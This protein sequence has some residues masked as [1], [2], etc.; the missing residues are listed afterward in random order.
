M[1]AVRI[2]LSSARRRAGNFVL[3]AASTAAAV[4]MLGTFAAAA[5]SSSFAGLAGY[6]VYAK[7]AFV[8]STGAMLLFVALSGWF[9]SEHYLAK[10]RHE[11]AL[12]LLAGMR[13]RLAFGLL[14]AELAVAIGAGFAGGITIGA[15]LSRLFSLVLGALMRTDEP[16]S[17]AFGRVAIAAASGACLLQ[18]ALA[19][20]RAVVEVSR[21]S[22]AALIRSEREPEAPSKGSAPAAAAGALLIAASYA[23]AVFSRGVMAEN[24]IL[25]VLIGAVLGTF[26]VFD[27]LVPALA[28]FIR[29]RA[30]GLGAAGTFAAAQIA[31]R[32]RRNARL[33]ALT[34]V[35]I[36]MAAAA[37][38]TVLAIRDWIRTEGGTYGQD[39]L[40]GAL[41]FIGG[42][43]SF[44]FALSAVV[45]LASRAAADARDDLGR[46]LELRDLGASRGTVL[47]AL[48]LQNAFLF[49]LPLAFGLAHSAV[50]L[51]MLRSFATVSSAG[52]TLAVCAA[53]IACFALLVS[54][55]SR[56]QLDITFDS[57]IVP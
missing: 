29:S 40:F 23:A 1:R 8:G 35:L 30:H 34:A 17:L 24:L 14:A 54:L 6:R 42:F 41:F 31:F 20:C 9:L 47:L 15:T 46:R 13:A 2:L 11:I 18:F 7:R 44:V 21:T 26:L 4:A 36:G 10:R 48:L 16:P 28:I 49:G 52:P 37:S 39:E 56:S 57:E 19:A 12:W 33:L 53:A 22:I 25:P 51:A 50:A 43:L 27:A 45:L 3:L 38:G 32:S 55:L 5:S